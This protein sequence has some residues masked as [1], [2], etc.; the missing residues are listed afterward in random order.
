MNGKKVL[1][2]TMSNI[3]N[4]VN[5]IL[6]RN[7]LNKDEIKYFIFHQ[8]SKIVIENL[9]K[10]L[11]LN[12]DKVYQDLKNL[13]N[14]V[15]STIPINMQKLIKNGKIKKGDKILIAGFGV[16]YSMGAAIINY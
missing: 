16:G 4:L 6:R 8:A 15:S 1:M 11:N 5:K 2:F 10:K 13:G 9:T 7:N 3:P 14:T 12:N